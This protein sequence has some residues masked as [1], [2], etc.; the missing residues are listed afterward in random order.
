MANRH[1]AKFADIWKHLTLLEVLW[2]ERPRRC[3]ETHAGTAFYPLTP[4]PERTYGIYHFLE[5]VDSSPPLASS[6]YADAGDALPRE[7]LRPVRPLRQRS[8]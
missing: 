7:R 8:G 3:W 6:A 4:S 2:I 1:F 5:S